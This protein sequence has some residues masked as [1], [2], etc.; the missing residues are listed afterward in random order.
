MKKYFMHIDVTMS[1]IVEIEAENEE[2]AKKELEKK[3]RKNPY[4][5]ANGFS[6]FVDYQVIDIEENEY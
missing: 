1:K 5:I 2:D 6:H 3:F 4:D